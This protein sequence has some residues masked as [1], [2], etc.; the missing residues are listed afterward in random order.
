MSHVILLLFLLLSCECSAESG[1]EYWI[2]RYLSVSYPLKDIYVT[3]SYGSRRDPF[4]GGRAFHSGLDLRAHYEDVYSMFDGVVDTVSC[5]SRSGIYVRLRHGEYVVSYCHLSK[6]FVKPGDIVIAGDVVG[7]SGNSG[8]SKG[9]HLHITVR[10]KGELINPS[11]LLVYIREVRSEVIQSLGYTSFLGR[12]LDC[13]SFFSLHSSAAMEQQ[14]KYGIPASVTLSQMAY[15]SAW[16]RSRLAVVGN[17]YFGIKCSRQWLESG[18]PY[19]LHD[20]DRRSEKFCNYVSIAESIEHHSRLLMSDRYRDC[21]KYSPTDY[22]NW[23]VALK[24]AGYATK[25]DYVQCCEKL[26]KR[27][28]LYLYDRMALRD[29]SYS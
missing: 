15:E 1:N 18:K 21:Q 20:D 17:N 11:V 7:K 25:K 16:G 24:K 29:A 26:I 28:K 13:E 8:R 9:A 5:D 4:T 10:Y 22:H 14:K 12:D 2:D 23:L 6:T 27:Y 3:S 19:S